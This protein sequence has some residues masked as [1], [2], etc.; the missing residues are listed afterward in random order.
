[1][2]E[3]AAM[4]SMEKSLTESSS[5]TEST[6]L[7]V[8]E[9]KGDMNHVGRVLEDKVDY[10][11]EESLKRKLELPLSEYLDDVKLKASIPDN[12][13]EAVKLKLE[14]ESIFTLESLS[15]FSVEDL[16]K[17]GLSYGLS[18]ILLTYLPTFPL[19]SLKRRRTSSARGKRNLD[20]REGVLHLFS[21]S[22]ELQQEN[23]LNEV[24]LEELQ[25]Q[26]NSLASST[27]PTHQPQSLLVVDASQISCTVCNKIIKLNKPGTA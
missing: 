22:I 21:L 19:P 13:M 1:M 26:V 14:S 11:H 9:E 27:E 10:N 15:L 24:S 18:K 16:Q 12:Q 17:M 23:L 8:D 2:E 20:G 5:L 25:Q 3:V 6:S 4:L 7:A